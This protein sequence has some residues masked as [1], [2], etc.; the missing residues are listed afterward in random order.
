MSSRRAAPWILLLALIAPYAWVSY[1]YSLALLVGWGDGWAHLTAIRRTLDAGLFPGDLFFLGEPT[2]PYYSLSHV[3]FAWASELSGRAPHELFMSAPPLI[4]AAIML[5]TFAWLRALSGDVRV[6]LAGTALELVASVPGGPWQSLSFPRNIAMVPL[7]LSWLAFLHA[8]RH[9]ASASLLASGAALGACLATHFFTGGICLGGLVLHEI[10]LEGR[11][12]RM[13]PLVVVVGCG[14]VIASPWIGSLIDARRHRA[15]QTHFVF[16]AERTSWEI[17]PGHPWSRILGATA[18]ADVMPP[19]LW[20]GVIAG[21]VTSVMRVRRGADDLADRY[22]LIAVSACILVV[23]TPLFSLGI[24]AFGVWARRL[25]LIAPFSLLFGRGAALLIDGLRSP[26]VRRWASAALL[27]SMLVAL[28]APVLRIASESPEFNDFLRRHGPLGT[29]D[30]AHELAASGGPGRVVLS[31][32]ETSYLLP[33][34][35]GSYVV[36][37]P[38]AHGSPYVDHNSR[39]TAAREFYARG[40]IVPRLFAILDEYGVDMVAVS[41][42]A[43]WPQQ[44]SAAELLARLRALPQ[45]RDTGCCGGITFLR[46]LGHAATS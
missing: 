20:V 33:Y 10:A 18:V 4:A 46:Y 26:P 8:R 31:D 21:F 45:F 23:F 24:A 42:N 17:L 38:P 43:N 41:S 36:V 22:A 29:W 39:L 9:G 13:A 14:L 7:Y 15:A 12:A 27:A 34:F 11:R 28:F 25:L 37:M 44:G 16:A 19:L 1:H 30:Y 2:P 32:P 3:L 40:T 35:L 5:A 6:A